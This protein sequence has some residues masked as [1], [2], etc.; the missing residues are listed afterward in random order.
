MTLNKPL[1][2]SEMQIPRVTEDKDETQLGDF[3]YFV[4]EDNNQSQK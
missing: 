4:R 3:T 1:N 2:I